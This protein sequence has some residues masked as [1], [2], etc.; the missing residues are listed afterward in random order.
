MQALASLHPTR[1]SPQTAYRPVHCSLRTYRPMHVRKMI[2][3]L[4]RWTYYRGHNGASRKGRRHPNARTPHAMRTLFSPHHRAR[5][6]KR[7][8]ASLCFP[9]R[10]HLSL[11][12]MWLIRK[13]MKCF[14]SRKTHDHDLDGTLGSPRADAN[15]GQPTPD[16]KLA[17]DLLSP[18]QSSCNST[19]IHPVSPSVRP[20][21]ILSFAVVPARR[22][23]K[24][25][26][27]K[28]PHHDTQ[29]K[30]CSPLPNFPT[31]GPSWPKALLPKNKVSRNTTPIQRTRN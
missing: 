11:S 24:K 30:S 6:S 31:T 18:P 19:C 1:R 13:A 28:C 25:E 3:H 26:K 4:D 22:N 23:A 29:P 15:S 20:H 7:L 27:R 5:R 14:D 21:F 17:T 10:V 8:R 9:V 16:T 2:T 12:S